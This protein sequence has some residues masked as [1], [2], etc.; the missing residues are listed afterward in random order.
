MCI[1]TQ[2]LLLLYEKPATPFG[3]LTQSDENNRT[4][5]SAPIA[6]S[7]AASEVCCVQITENYERLCEEEIFKTTTTTLITTFVS[8]QVSA[9]IS[10][11][12][13]SSIQTQLKPCGDTWKVEKEGEKENEN[14][15]ICYRY[16]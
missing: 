11:K 2:V 13:L 9:E 8:K 4:S 5:H 16:R 10:R 7:L 14:E 15:L 3:L 6:R 12:T 1:Q